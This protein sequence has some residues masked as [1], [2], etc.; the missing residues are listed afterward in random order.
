MA[1][2]FFMQK[3]KQFR[4]LYAFGIIVYEWLTQNK[5]TNQNLP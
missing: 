5:I 4:D 2:E 3:G 1:P